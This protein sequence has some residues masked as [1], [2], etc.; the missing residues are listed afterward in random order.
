[1]QVEMSLA[2]IERVVFLDVPAP[3]PYPLAATSAKARRESKNE[4][5]K[6]H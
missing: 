1:M 4:Q 3:R 5:G 6:Q 2:F